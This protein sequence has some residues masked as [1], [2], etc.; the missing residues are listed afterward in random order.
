MHKCDVTVIQ[1]YIDLRIEILSKR[2][3]TTIE[4]NYIVFLIQGV[5]TFQDIQKF[6][7][8]RVKDDIETRKRYIKNRF[9]IPKLPKGAKP[10]IL[11]NDISSQQHFRMFF[12]SYYGEYRCT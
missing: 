10:T 11:F 3:W 2:I 5:F 8:C 12:Q 4:D 1:K 6:L 9:I 7:I